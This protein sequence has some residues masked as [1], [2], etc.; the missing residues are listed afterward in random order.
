[1]VNGFK[2]I[3]KKIWL[4]LAAIVMITILF[5]PILNILGLTL[6]TISD[7]IFYIIASIIVLFVTHHFIFNEN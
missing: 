6:I 5:I 7:I 2:G 3:L 1:M 4:I